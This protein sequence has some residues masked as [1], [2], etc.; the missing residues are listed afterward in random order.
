M[1]AV[2]KD[3]LHGSLEKSDTEEYELHLF[4]LFQCQKVKRIAYLAF[5]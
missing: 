1:L 4:N 5:L 2:G 3:A